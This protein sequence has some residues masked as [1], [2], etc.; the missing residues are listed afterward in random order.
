MLSAC[1]TGLGTP[2]GGEQLIGLRRSLY[3]AGARARV[4]SLWKVDDEATL[5]LMREFYRRLWS[6]GA[7]KLDALRGAQLAMLARNRAIRNG[8]GL[9][10]TWGAFVLEG[11]WQ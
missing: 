3:L 11:E 5:E 2:E 4:T 10:S 8:D 6:E 9:P 1:E 7:G